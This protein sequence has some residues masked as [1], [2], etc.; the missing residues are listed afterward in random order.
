MSAFHE[1]LNTI[2]DGQTLHEKSITLQAFIPVQL[3]L[4][5]LFYRL[6]YP[7]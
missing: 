5:D 6:D 3:T 1:I 7:C 2:P 4:K